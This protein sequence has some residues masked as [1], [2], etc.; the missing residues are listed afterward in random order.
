MSEETQADIQQN[1]QGG[2]PPTK[3]QH[4]MAA[5]FLAL[6]GTKPFEGGDIAPGITR[7]LSGYSSAYLIQADESGQEYVLIDAGADASAEEIMAVLRYKGVD[8]TAVKAILLTHGHPD[9]SAGLRKF[10][11]AEVYV[12]AG[13]HDFIVGTGEA[14]GPLLHL[15]GKKPDLAI[16]DST[17]LHDLADGQTVTVGNVELKV[18]AVPGHTRGSFAF[19]VRDILFVGD[20]TTFDKHGKASKPPLPVSYDVNEE[21]ESLE[22]LIERFDD[23]GIVVN[24]VVPSHSGEGTLQAVR[25]LATSNN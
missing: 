18:Y 13:D 25:D 1:L 3:H 5:V 12:G 7:I 19:L 14:D 4:G 10:P 6:M 9:H 15:M 23:Q 8:A 24:T 21:A 16:A 20:A 17:K 11:E 22:H 2:H